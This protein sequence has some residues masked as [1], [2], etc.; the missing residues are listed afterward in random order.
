MITSWDNQG[1][2]SYNRNEILERNVSPSSEWVTCSPEFSKCLGSVSA[3][4]VYS[5]VTVTGLAETNNLRRHCV[6][7]VWPS[8][9][10]HNP[11]KSELSV[12]ESHAGRKKM[13]ESMCQDSGSWH[14]KWTINCALVSGGAVAVGV[15]SGETRPSDLTVLATR[16]TASLKTTSDSS[17]SVVDGTHLA[18]V[19]LDVHIPGLFQFNLVSGPWRGTGVGYWLLGV[20]AVT[21]S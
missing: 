16:Q 10:W 1:G 8:D 18:Q 6:P 4:D 15:W 2:V 9:Y 5:S 21:L 7:V 20:Q 3:W 13:L 11:K 14:K 17:R 19:C 12:Q